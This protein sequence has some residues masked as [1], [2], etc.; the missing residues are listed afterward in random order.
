MPFFSV[1][2]SG[3]CPACT[4]LLHALHRLQEIRLRC[5]MPSLWKGV[6]LEAK[7]IGQIFSWHVFRASV[8]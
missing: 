8:N 3:F 6:R 7:F 1:S 4:G 5:I 2:G